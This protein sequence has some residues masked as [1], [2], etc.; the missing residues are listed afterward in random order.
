VPGKKKVT[1]YYDMKLKGLGMPVVDYTETGLAKV[2]MQVIKAL[3]GDPN[4]KKYG[5][6]YEFFKYFFII[7]KITR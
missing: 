7:L 3:A 1:K 5:Y 4:N 2:D 6:A